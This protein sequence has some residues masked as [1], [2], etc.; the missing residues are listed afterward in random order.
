M[1]RRNPIRLLWRIT[2]LVRATYLGILVLVGVVAAGCGGMQQA[3]H[4]ASRSAVGAGFVRQ[5][6]GSQAAGGPVVEAGKTGVSLRAMPNGTFGLM[7][8]LKNRTHSQLVLQD[9][10]AVVPRGSFVRPLGAHLSPYFQC[11]PNCSRH[12]VMRGPFGTERPAAVRV[13]PTRA[14]QAQLDF[15]ITGCGAL[16]GVSTTPITQ[17]VIVY[18][19][20]SGAIFRQTIAL[21]S[22]QLLLQPSGLTACK[23]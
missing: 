16:Q 14:A 17:A 19:D 7:V 10:R 15:A 23:A 2:R 4:V 13:R 22:S 12:L 18:R 11:K 3:A 6:I 9:V 20:P 5:Q 1:I 8:V 21:R